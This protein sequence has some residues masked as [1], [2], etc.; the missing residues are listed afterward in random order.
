MIDPNRNSLKK[1]STVSSLKILWAYKKVTSSCQK[2][3]INRKIKITFDR[4]LFLNKR[5]MA[6]PIQKGI[7]DTN[8]R[9]RKNIKCSSYALVSNKQALFPLFPC[10]VIHTESTS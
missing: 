4:L 3:V 8:N 6:I 1:N 2:E 10:V 7:L 5:R 9:K